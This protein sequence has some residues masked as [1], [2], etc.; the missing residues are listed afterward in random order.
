MVF[1]CQGLK[2]AI[3]EQANI[4]LS[5][6]IQASH[7][8]IFARDWSRDTSRTY[9]AMKIQNKLLNIIYI[10]EQTVFDQAVFKWSLLSNLRLR[11][12]IFQEY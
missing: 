5:G 11:M 6:A 4:G 3:K 9:F 12:L 8:F 1:V 7:G 10:Y 2:D